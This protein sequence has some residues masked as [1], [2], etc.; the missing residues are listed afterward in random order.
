MGPAKDFPAVIEV[1]VEIPAGSR[2]KYEYD[3]HA[4]VIRLDRVLSSAVY[5]NFDYDF[6]EGTR[7][8]DGR[9]EGRRLQGPLRRAS[10]R[11]LLAPRCAAA[12]LAPQ[13]PGDRAVLPDLQ[14][15]R[16]QVGRDRGL[17]G[18]GRD[19]RDPAHRSRTLAGRTASGGGRRGLSAWRP[20]SRSWRSPGARSGSPTPG[21][22]TSRDPATR[23]W[24][25]C[26]TTSRSR[27]ERCA[28]P[29]VGPRSEERR[30]GKECRS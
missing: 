7:A 28:G 13:A 22:C 6:I 26:A 19:P 27:R 30:V 11:A 1:V 14:E 25:W 5:Y 2:N 23:S 21:R 15:P 12:G 4:K 24:T 29:A 16:G 8:E 17:G 20:R 18:C 3:E 10:G 9:R